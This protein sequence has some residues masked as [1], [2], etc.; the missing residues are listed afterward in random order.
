MVPGR[1]LATY[2][3]T[4]KVLTDNSVQFNRMLTGQFMEANQKVID[5][6]EGT[7]ASLELWFRVLHKKMAD[8]MCAISIKDVWEAH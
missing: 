8:E 7:V 5:V 4:R 3:V 6:K 1:I 2:K